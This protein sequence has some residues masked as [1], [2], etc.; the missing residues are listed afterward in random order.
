MRVD[1]QRHVLAA[2]L[3]GINRY[4]LLRRLGVPQGRSRRRRKISRPQGF[5]PRTV[6]PVVSLYTGHAIPA[7]VVKIGKVE[8]QN[9]QNFKS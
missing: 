5:D 3:P 9:T 6:Q 8:C 2:P 1:G 4:Q 7:N